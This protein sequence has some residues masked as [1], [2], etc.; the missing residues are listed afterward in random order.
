MDGNRE[1]ARDY[2]EAESMR[3][4]MDLRAYLAPR[5]ESDGGV[6]EAPSQ[7]QL[8]RQSLTR[9]LTDMGTNHLAAYEMIVGYPAFAAKR[10]QGEVLFAYY[11]LIRQIVDDHPD[12]PVP[13][14]LMRFIEQEASDLEEFSIVVEIGMMNINMLTASEQMK[15]PLEQFAEYVSRKKQELDAYVTHVTAE[16]YRKYGESVAEFANFSG[17]SYAL[18]KELMD[19]HKNNPDQLRNIIA[20][21]QIRTDQGMTVARL[22]HDCELISRHSNSP[23]DQQSDI[24]QNLLMTAEGRM[25]MIAKFEHGLVNLGVY[26]PERC[27][28]LFRKDLRTVAA[29]AAAAALYDLYLMES[30]KGD[31]VTITGHLV[32]YRFLSKQGKETAKRLTTE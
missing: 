7:R 24:K 5:T 27:K 28:G 26:E 6:E 31:R 32:N 9:S 18:E 1:A 15:G 16:L 2:D 21:G 20:A 8:A 25:A 3:L 17:E 14:G 19:K 22:Q 4:R 29:K 10:P 12:A 11:G 23:M 30:A 13:A